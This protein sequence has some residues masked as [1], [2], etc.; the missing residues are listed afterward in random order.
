MAGYGYGEVIGRA[1]VLAAVCGF[2]AGATV[3]TVAVVAWPYLPAIRLDW[4]R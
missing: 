1:I 3:V 2:L 4:G